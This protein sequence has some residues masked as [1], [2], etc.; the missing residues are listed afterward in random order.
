M[1]L[2]RAVS[3]IGLPLKLSWI[4]DKNAV[5]EYKRLHISFKQKYKDTH[6][7][8]YMV[9]NFNVKVRNGRIFFGVSVQSSNVKSVRYL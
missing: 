1:S 7:Q 9:V 5:Y 3:F 4:F 6:F 2:G 8:L